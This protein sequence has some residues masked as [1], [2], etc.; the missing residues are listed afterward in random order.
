M[1]LHDT[2]Y[3][4]DMCC[5]LMWSS[6]SEET[7]RLLRWRFCAC[8]GSRLVTGNETTY[9][10]TA[11]QPSN[12][13]ASKLSDL[14]SQRALSE[15]R[16]LRSVKEDCSVE[17]CS[18]SLSGVLQAN[19]G[20]A[21]SKRRKPKV[22]RVHC[23]SVADDADASRRSSKCRPQETDNGHSV[24]GSPRKFCNSNNDK[25]GKG[26]KLRGCLARAFQVKTAGTT[27]SSARGG[28]HSCLI[29]AAKR[30]RGTIQKQ[31]VPNR[32]VR[33][34]R[35]VFDLNATWGNAP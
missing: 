2:C 21:G 19:Q 6:V 4:C 12:F 3:R 22:L 27:G 34:E 31:G 8:C 23:S 17:R 24:T 9:S 35:Q 18:L 11:L 25:Y 28:G 5:A 10:A 1:F 26:S 20:L 32:Q 7:G 14:R 13:L 30:W 15:D 29:L 16:D 33:Q